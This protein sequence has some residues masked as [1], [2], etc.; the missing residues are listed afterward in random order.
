MITWFNKKIADAGFI[1]NLKQR[2]DRLQSAYKALDNANIKGIKRF[3]A[4]TGM[5]KP[6]N[7]CTQSHIDIAKLQI[8]HNWEYVL[9]LEDD[10]HLDVFYD[11]QSENIDFK[12]VAGNISEELQYHKPDILWLGTRPLGPVEKISNMFVKPSKTVMAHA[13]LG[14]LRYANFV[15]DNLDWRDQGCVSGGWPLDFFISELNNKQDWRIYREQLTNRESILNNDLKI[16]MTIPNIFVQGPS[17]SDLENRF[18]DHKLWIKSCFEN[19][20]NLSELNIKK[21]LKRDE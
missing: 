2:K 10:I 4:V 6:G 11:G 21:I 18:V 1:I 14:S 12:A 3:N 8:K 17:H 13:Y 7:G 20:V 5:P 19:W 16:Y 15:V 9:Y